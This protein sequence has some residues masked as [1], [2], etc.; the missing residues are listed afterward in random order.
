VNALKTTSTI[1]KTDFEAPRTSTSRLLGLSLRDLEYAVAVAK[2]RNFGRAAER[3]GVSQAALSEQV[4]KLEG[5]LGV[6][7]FERTKRRVDPTPRGAT[8]LAQA[9]ALLAEARR[10]LDDARR[11]AEPLT[12]EFRLGVIATLGPYYLPSLLH[13]GRERFPNLLMRLRESQTD[14]LLRALRQGE[15]D[16]ALLALPIAGDGLTIEPLFFEPFRLACPMDHPLASRASVRLR[17]L[18]RGKLLLMEEGHCMR[19]QAIE[20]CNVRRLDPHTRFASSLEM[21]RHMIA[22]GEGYSVLPLMATRSH[23]DMNGLIAF[24]DIADAD[25]GRRIG[26][27]W[28]ATETRADDLRQI[29][30]YMRAHVPDGIAPL[31]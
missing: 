29:A 30:A 3:C 26:L 6:T 18:P 27:V 7:L 21:L 28:R 20:L 31:P 11:S 25:A 19:D 17:D 15:L 5:V 9:E 1:G 16:A 13:G 8:L 24:R 22:A 10:F 23:A 14:D 2:E 12:G 4:R